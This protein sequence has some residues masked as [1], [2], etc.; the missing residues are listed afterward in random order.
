MKKKFVNQNFTDIG[1]KKGSTHVLAGICGE[2]FYWTL[3]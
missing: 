1:P 2:K 3:F